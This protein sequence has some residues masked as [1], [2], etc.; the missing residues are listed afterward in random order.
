M[1]PISLSHPHQYRI[2][3]SLDKSSRQSE[4]RLPVRAVVPA[5]NNV[6]AR[7][8]KKA[9]LSK[10]HQVNDSKKFSRKVVIRKGPNAPGTE[11]RMVRVENIPFDL[12]WK[13]VK[14][15]MSE[16]GMIE[17]CDVEKGIAT[18]TFATHKEAARCIQTYN[19]G[20]MNGRKIRVVFI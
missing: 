19:G 20:D 12:T 5:R 11:K 16:V 9:T 14:G 1:S 2:R 13:D 8:Q 18:I 17:R 10:P 4:K 15:A 6:R 7:V 3:K